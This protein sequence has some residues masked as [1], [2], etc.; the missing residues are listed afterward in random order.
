M[1]IIFSKTEVQNKVKR[2]HSH[3]LHSS[4]PVA[5]GGATAIPAPGSCGGAAVSHS[6]ENPPKV[7]QKGVRSKKKK[8]VS[9]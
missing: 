5:A 9:V 6:P 4:Q 2:K 7:E 8:K 1:L 3:W